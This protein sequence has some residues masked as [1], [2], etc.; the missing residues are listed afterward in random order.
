MKTRIQEFR[1]S[2]GYK[3]AK[4]FAE[5]NGFNVKTYTN[6]EQGVSV[7]AL[8]TMW[9]L[10]DIFG[11]SIEELA[12]RSVRNSLVHGVPVD[13]EMVE[14]SSDERIL[15]DCFR[16]CTTQYREMLLTTARSFRDSSKE[17]ASNSESLD[18]AVN[19]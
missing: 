2:A 12:G 9:Q 14:L 11:C 13:N 6:W 3:S 17:S 8:E 16:S 5:A 7:P 4:A 19:E 18:K 1:K 15:I 10:A